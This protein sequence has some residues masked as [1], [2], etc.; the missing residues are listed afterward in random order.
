VRDPWPA[1]ARDLVAARNVNDIDDV[2]RELARVVRRE[3][4]A[5]ALDEQNLAPIAGLKRLECA[6]VRG[7]VFANR[8]VRAPARLDRLDALGGERLVRDQEL[9]VLAREDVVGHGRCARKMSARQTRG[10]KARV[11]RLYSPRRRWHSAS[12]SAVF[13]EPTGLAS[14]KHQFQVCTTSES[15]RGT[16]R[17][18]W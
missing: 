4:V 13:P 1:L 5:A 2:V 11:P 8:R 9:L 3:V 16:L 12:V 7:N 17:F 15:G 14:A 10:A 6:R 18:Q